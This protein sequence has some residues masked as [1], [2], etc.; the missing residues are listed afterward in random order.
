[1]KNSVSLLP[2]CLQFCGFQYACVLEKIAD[3][4]QK[5]QRIWNKGPLYRTDSCS[6]IG[7]LS[8]RCVHV[9]AKDFWL[10]PKK[11][12]E[13]KIFGSFPVQNVCYRIKNFLI[14]LK[15]GYWRF[16]EFSLSFHSV[17]LKRPERSHSVNIQLWCNLI[18]PF[19]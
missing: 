1:M 18:L 10:V 9:F 12:S 13:Q 2:F 7:Y 8:F 16:M 11:M 14:I 6:Y 5:E 3:F 19:N 4:E 15:M 17:N